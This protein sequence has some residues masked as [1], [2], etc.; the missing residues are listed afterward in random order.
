MAATLQG[1][2]GTLN[3]LLLSPQAVRLPLLCC[4]IRPLTHFV[5]FA[6]P[7]RDTPPERPSRAERNLALRASRSRAALQA[8]LRATDGGVPNE[9]GRTDALLPA[10]EGERTT[11]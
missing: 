7:S 10:A 11:I 8:V 9:A 6:R 4:C 2:Q 1:Y 3:A 5:A